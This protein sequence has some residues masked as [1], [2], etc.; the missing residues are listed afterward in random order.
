M[1][2]EADADAESGG[3]ERGEKAIVVSAAAA[4]AV[5]NLGESHA[6]N[7][8]EIG[9]GGIGDGAFS[10]VGLKEAKGAGGELVGGGDLVEDE[11]VA[12][13]AGEEKLA[14]GKPVERAEVGFGGQGAESGEGAGLIVDCMVTPALPSRVIALG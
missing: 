2:A 12:V 9:A 5:T 13:E 10:R 1:A 4:E 3:G 8:N 14:S 6:G 11:M 7:E